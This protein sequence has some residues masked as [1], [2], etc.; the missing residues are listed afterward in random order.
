MREQ[1]YALADASDSENTPVA[2]ANVWL[3]Q[4]IAE[5]WDLL[6]TTDPQ[7]YMVTTTLTAVDGERRYSFD[8]ASVFSPVASDFMALVGVDFVRESERSPLE[9]FS[10]H[11]RGTLDYHQSL[12]L[13]RRGTDVRYMVQGQGVDGAQTRLVFDVLPAAGPNYE[14]HY[15]QAAPE[16]VDDTATFDGVNG[17][18]DWAIYDV[19]ILIANREETRTDVLERKRAAIQK[20]IEGMAPRRDVGR[21]GQVA[22]VW[23]RRSL[24]GRRGTRLRW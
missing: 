19:A 14:V 16:L 2:D 9:P 20:R 11:D 17:W 4:A 3:D 24:R 22:T 7:R 15:V 18:E 5:L 10:F 23:S 6:V 8:D 12:P 1:A 13:V 21:S